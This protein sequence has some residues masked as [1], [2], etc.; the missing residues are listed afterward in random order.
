MNVTTFTPV[1]RKRISFPIASVTNVFK[2]IFSNP[3]RIVFVIV[4]LLAAFGLYT[5]FFG[6]SDTNTATK[7]LP[8]K[9]SFE[10]VAKTKD[11]KNTNGNFKVDVTGTFKAESL[12]VQGQRVVARNGKEFL[13]VNMEVSNPYNVALY[14][15]P[16]DTFR[17]LG[18]DGKK[19]APT[20]HQGNVEVRPQSTK[21]SNV[22]FIVPKGTKKFKVEIG[23][24]T[25]DKVLLEFSL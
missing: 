2:K 21:T 12:L 20:A 19:Y 10:V 25:G 15:Y 22:G 9:Q 13:I 14:T 16:V 1:G 8:L 5:I 17:L 4:A 23:E 7:I 18:V 6:G 11:G 24:L 3:K